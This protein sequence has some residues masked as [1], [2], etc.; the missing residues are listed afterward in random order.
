MRAAITRTSSPRT[1][2]LLGNVT[3]PTVRE[4]F[5][6]VHVVRLAP[7]KEGIDGQDLRHWLW[8][9]GAHRTDH[10]VRRG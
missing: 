1:I 3:F 7:K 8:V 9:Y 2:Y 6:H 10:G 5:E 4:E